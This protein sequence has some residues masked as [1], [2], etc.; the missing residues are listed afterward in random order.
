MHNRA[1]QSTSSSLS[2]RV[3]NVQGAES[4]QGKKKTQQSKGRLTEESRLH[5]SLLSY[6]HMRR[7]GFVLCNRTTVDGGGR[8]EQSRFVQALV[9]GL[10]CPL[11]QIGD[12][13]QFEALSC[14]CASLRSAP[15]TRGRADRQDLEARCVC[16]G[17]KSLLWWGGKHYGRFYQHRLLWRLQKCPDKFVGRQWRDGHPGRCH[18]VSAQRQMFVW[19]PLR[20][21]LLHCQEERKTGVI[22]QFVLFLN[23]FGQARALKTF[24]CCQ[25][26]AQSVFTSV[27]W[28][29]RIH[30]CPFLDLF[31]RH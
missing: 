20:D 3:R 13:K 11:C 8:R 22:G 18:C 23:E 24:D 29:S 30:F 19:P 26:D 25:Y 21:T 31:Y 12:N 7:Y 16:Q 2:P 10:N 6:L 4:Q 5:P 27:E 28:W 15:P 17:G 1:P 9:S 14:L